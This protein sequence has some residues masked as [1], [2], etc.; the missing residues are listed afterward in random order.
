MYIIISFDK[1]VMN[2]NIMYNLIVN[3]A[4]YIYLTVYIKNDIF[5]KFVRKC[6]K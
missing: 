5:A 3:K 6:T 1:L 2:P 4:V